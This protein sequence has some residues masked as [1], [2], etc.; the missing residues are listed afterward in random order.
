M[1]VNQTSKVTNSRLNKGMALAIMSFAVLSVSVVLNLYQWYHYH[2]DREHVAASLLKVKQDYQYQ[3]TVMTNLRQKADDHLVSYQVKLAQLHSEV[4][5][6]NALG[7]TLAKVANIPENEYDVLQNMA[8]G[9]PV[10]DQ[11]QSLETKLGSVLEEI[12]QIDW[13]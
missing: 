13:R 4:N 12:D 9:G 7:L 5:R 8:Q 10:S 11:Y 1:K 3:Q 6:L 2:S